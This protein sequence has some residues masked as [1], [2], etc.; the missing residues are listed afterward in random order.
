MND[1]FSYNVSLE[2]VLCRMGI[3]GDRHSLRQISKS[4]WIIICDRLN[5]ILE[6]FF[7][8]LLLLFVLHSFNGFYLFVF[9]LFFFCLFCI[10]L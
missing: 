4:F 7:L 3:F 6:S 5:F 8:L 9:L 10:L 2:L 1:N